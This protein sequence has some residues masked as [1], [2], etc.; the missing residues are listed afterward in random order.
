MPLPLRIK[1]TLLF[2][3]QLLLLVVVLNIMLNVGMWVYLL[4]QGKGQLSIIYHTEKVSEVINGNKISAA[5]KQKIELIQEIKTYAEAHLG[6]KKTANYATYYD[7]K[8]KPILWMLTACAPFEFKEQLW[9]FPLLGEVSYKGF[10]D[11]DLAFKEAIPL[12][13]QHLDVDIGKVS[14]WSTLG[15]LSDPILSSMLDDDEGALAALIIHELTHA[16]LYLPNNVDFN[17][18]F[19]S[20]VGKQGALQFITQ[21]YGKQSAELSNYLQANKEEDILKSFLLGKKLMLEDFYLKLH[22]NQ[23]AIEKKRLK[24]QLIESIIKE[25]YALPIYNWK[26]KINIAHKI[27]LSGNAYFMSFNRYDAQYNE[28]YKSYTSLESDLK[29][30]IM[31]VKVHPALK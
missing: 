14:A 31:Y 24:Q 13:M 12:K 10:F 22:K 18:N 27:R 15:I 30:L 6:L 4:R 7:Q 17:E 1:Y 23:S 19:A 25:M 29:K 3:W 11:Y 8:G 5:Q 9:E 28:I 26:T 16:T 20:F 21:K 2:L